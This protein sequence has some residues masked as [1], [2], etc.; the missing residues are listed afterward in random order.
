MA[1][2]LNKVFVIGHLTQD[3][4]MRTTPGSPTAIASPG[5]RAATSSSAPA[6]S[7]DQAITVIRGSGR[8]TPEGAGSVFTATVDGAAVG[9]G[10]E[11][12]FARSRG[13]QPAASAR[14]RTRS[15]IATGRSIRAE[16][17]PIPFDER[18]PSRAYWELRA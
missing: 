8:A 9:T 1:R 13:A 17:T 11:R 3:P 12:A 7:P 6:P 10:V 5:A 14:K 15:A 16:S 18:A 2:D 4:E